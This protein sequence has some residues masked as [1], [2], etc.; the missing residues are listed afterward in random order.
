MSDEIQ[1]RMVGSSGPIRWV[2]ESNSKALAILTAKGRNKIL[3]ESLESSLW[4]W[5]DKFLPMRF[6]GYVTRSPFNYK[7]AASTR[8]QKQANRTPPLVGKGPRSGALR[9]LV[10][11][12][13]IVCTSKGG[14]VR[15]TITMP[16][17]GANNVQVQRVLGSVPLSEVQEIAKWM[18]E[19]MPAA[20]D[21]GLFGQAQAR[22]QKIQQRN[23]ARAS[24]K[25]ASPRQRKG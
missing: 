25:S 1:P 11:T 3:R 4:Q 6:T 23:E 22:Q 17:G 19:E 8:A 13:T 18:A 14:N 16:R 20:I 5:R 7:P 10:M 24:R 9:R 15:G 12:G 2:I 21:R